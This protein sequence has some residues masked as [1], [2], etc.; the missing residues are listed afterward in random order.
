[1]G[2]T[3]KNQP[4]FSEKFPAGYSFKQHVFCSVPLILKGE[5]LEMTYLSNPKDSDQLV[6]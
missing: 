6:N 2:K 3:E 4:Y 5:P 1:M